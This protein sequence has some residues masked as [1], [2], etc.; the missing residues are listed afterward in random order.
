MSEAKYIEFHWAGYS[1]SGSTETWRVM[2]KNNNDG[3]IGTIKWYGSWRCYA[4]YPFPEC[5]FEKQCLRDIANFCEK[6]TKLQREKKL[7][8]LKCQTPVSVQVAKDK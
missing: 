1:K 6:V 2:P 4:F 7:G 3:L 5:V 8:I